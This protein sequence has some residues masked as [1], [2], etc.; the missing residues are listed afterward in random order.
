L[1]HNAGM[2]PRRRRESAVR[3]SKWPRGSSRSLTPPRERPTRVSPPRH[4]PDN[5]WGDR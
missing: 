2:R 1:P 3:G 4:R 5:N